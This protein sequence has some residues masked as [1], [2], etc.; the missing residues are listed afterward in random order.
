MKSGGEEYMAGEREG[1][2]SFCHDPVAIL[3]YW[4]AVMPVQA[5]PKVA[6]GLSAWAWCG[7]AM[8][9]GY[10]TSTAST[11]LTLTL[12]L[13]GL[14]V[15]VIFQSLLALQASITAA[16]LIP[17]LTLTLLPFLPHSQE[18]DP[19]AVVLRVYDGQHHDTGRQKGKDKKDLGRGRALE[20][21]GQDTI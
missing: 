19:Q 12:I 1:L 10:C 11:C 16:A 4:P 15:L 17:R 9:W 13:E 20:A 3:S 14:G 21:E 8:E 5:V 18:S 6:A 2:S 7:G